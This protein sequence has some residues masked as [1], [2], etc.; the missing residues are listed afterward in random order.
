MMSERRSGCERAPAVGWPAPPEERLAARGSP[1]RVRAPPG[2]GRFRERRKRA[3]AQEATAERDPR[4]ERFGS[5]K[6]N[7]AA[8]Q[9]REEAISFGV[10]GRTQAA[11]D[12]CDKCEWVQCREALMLAFALC[13]A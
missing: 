11:V 1:Q 9:A 8:E 2:A 7:C 5:F 4:R 3:G 6:G 10:A 13:A 12:A